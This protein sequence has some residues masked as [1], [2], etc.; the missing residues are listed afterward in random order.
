MGAKNLALV[1]FMASGK[2]TVGRLL[3]ESL[4]LPFVDLDEVVEAEAGMDVA[5]IFSREGEDAFRR[6][7]SL[8]LESVLAG[9]SGV[10]ACGGGIILREE[11]VRLLRENAVVFYLAVSAQA[12]LERACEDGTVRPL[13][14]VVDAAS[15]TERLLEE[16]TPRY[17]AAAHE[18]VDAEH[19]SPRE[20]AEE[21]A[22]RWRKYR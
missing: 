1:G 21:I 4:R 5:E 11:N 2:S 9:E 19:V 7:E 16:R 20:L 6:R 18:V 22:E 15:A 13:L 8:A 10:I 14:Q 12:A 17:L 3:A